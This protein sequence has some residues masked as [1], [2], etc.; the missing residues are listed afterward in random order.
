[1]L[2]KG[3]RHEASLLERGQS[4]ETEE[5]NSG[6]DVTLSEYEVAEVLVSSQEPAARPRTTSSGTAGDDF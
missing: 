5:Q 2:L 6:V 4:G 3:A 1:M